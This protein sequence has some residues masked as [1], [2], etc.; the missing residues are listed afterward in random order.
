[1]KK[2]LLFSLAI[3]IL[4]YTANAQ[5]GVAINKDGANPDPSALLDVSG[6]DG[7]VLIP[8]MTAAQRT[9]ISTPATGLVVYDTDSVRFYYYAGGW[10]T[11]ANPHKL[12]GGNNYAEFEDDG[13]LVFYGSS[14]TYDDIQVPALS[15]LKNA[16]AP[17]LSTFKNGTL[18]YSF[19]E[20]VSQNEEQVYFSVQIPH[21]WKQGTTLYPH[22]HFTGGT[23]SPDSVRWGLEYTW[24]NVNGTF[25]PTNIIY[26]SKKIGTAS[27]HQVIGF[28]G[29][30]PNTNQDHISSILVCRLFRNSSHPTEDTYSGDDVFLLQ[31]DIH[32]EV[33]TLGSRL[34][35]IK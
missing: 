17:T 27:V 25:G 13:M 18:L 8:R 26:C 16:N 15:T 30:T 19:A 32:Y 24:A 2:I 28:G 3:S 1:M 5:T 6:T 9:A 4:T 31:F 22:V 12:G 14:T 34:Q 21:S 35:W 10:N 11:I 23:T 29:I 7:G 20:Q 33:N